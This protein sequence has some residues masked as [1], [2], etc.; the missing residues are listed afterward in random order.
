[1]YGMPYFDAHC[2]TLSRCVEGGYDLWENDGH[3][4]LK[5]LSAYAPV[6]QVFSIF[7]TSKGKTE[8]ECMEQVLRQAALFKTA[9]ESWPELM[10]RCVL[11]LEG[12]ELIGCREE[13]LPRLKEWGVCW[14]NLTWNYP[15]ALSGS[16]KTG[17]GLS[18][19]GRSFVRRM[20]ELGLCVDV[21]HLSDKGFWELCEM[22]LGPIVASHSNS[23][24]LCPHIRNLTDE[25]AQAIFA[26]GGYVGINLYKAFLGEN[27]CMDTVIA[28]IE[29]FLELGGEDHLGMGTDFDGAD[30]PADLSGVQDIPRLWEALRR[31]NYR[32][33]VIEKLAYRNLDT[34]LKTYR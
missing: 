8:K 1:V 29:R 9:K 25:M 17:E 14:I 34:F 24:V 5:R 15:N 2:D 10:E 16:C 28:H 12:A 26:S 4:D 18:E 20:R 22:D 32:E 19:Q 13:L 21:S 27:P 11:S 7:Y 31:R 33:A 23:R 30:V 3:V 6:M